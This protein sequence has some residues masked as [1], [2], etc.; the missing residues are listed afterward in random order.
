M[1]VQSYPDMHRLKNRWEFRPPQA[2]LP[3]EFLEAW[4]VPAISSEIRILLQKPS[5]YF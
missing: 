2:F 3:Q 4:Q 5:K 1:E